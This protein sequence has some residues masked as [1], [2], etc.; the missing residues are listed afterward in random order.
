MKCLAMSDGNVLAE[1]QR[2]FF[3]SHP[4]VDSHYL[5]SSIDLPMIIFVIILYTPLRLSLTYQF[6]FDA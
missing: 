2:V 6:K 4:T 5:N 1:N 3:T